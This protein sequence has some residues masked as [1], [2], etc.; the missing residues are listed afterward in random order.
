VLKPRGRFI[1]NVWDRLEENEIAFVVDEAIATLF[2]EDPPH[3]FARTPHGYYDTG[4]IR[5]ELAE[6]GFA[7]VSAETVQ[8]SSCA[9]SPRDAGIG[10]CQGTPLR[11][12]IEARDPNGLSAATE[13]VTNAVVAR[14]GPGPVSAKMQAHVITAAI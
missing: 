9:A 1:F 13:A 8:R 5:A 2:R 6:A 3:F 14:F 4:V 7:T 12:E 11:N 10:F